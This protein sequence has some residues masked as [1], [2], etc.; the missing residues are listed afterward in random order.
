MASFLPPYLIILQP[1]NVGGLCRTCEVFNI[2]SLVVASDLVQ[3]T[4]VCY[5]KALIT[6]HCIKEFLSLSMTA[7]KWLPVEAVPPESLAAWIK[8]KKSEGYTIVAAEQ[9]TYE[10]T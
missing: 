9:V 10:V 3:K 8:D 1:V 2:A 6:T 7:E 5:E 4:K